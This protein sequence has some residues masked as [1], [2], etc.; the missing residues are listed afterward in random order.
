M[1]STAL[2]T[3]IRGKI[4]KK[5]RLFVVSGPSG[6]GKTTLCETLL[7]RGIG[8]VRSVSMTTRKMRGSERQNTDYIYIT[9]EQFKKQL[10]QGALLEHAKVFGAYYGTPKRFIMQALCEGRD[11]LLNI[12]VQGAAQIKRKCPQSVLVFIVPP[13]MAELERRLRRRS[14]DPPEQIR[15]RLQKAREELSAIK[16]YDFWVVNNRLDIAARDLEN[17]IVAIRHKI[18]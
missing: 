6:C 3:L 14:T 8:L 1:N 15:K 18:S 2:P 11:V 17:I 13:T 7:R 16:S 9:E 4:H 10:V 12:D 5:G